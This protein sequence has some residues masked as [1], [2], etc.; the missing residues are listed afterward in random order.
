FAQRA[1]SANTVAEG[2]EGLS[3]ARAPD[4]FAARL[5]PSGLGIDLVV[6]WHGWLLSRLASAR[7]PGSSPRPKPATGI[8]IKTY[9]TTQTVRSWAFRINSSATWW[10][11]IFF[12][13][14]N[15]FL[16]TTT[17]LHLFSRAAS[18]ISPATP[19]PFVLIQNS[20][21]TAL[22]GIPAFLKADFAFFNIGD[23]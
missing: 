13:Q 16:P 9:S 4:G 19:S 3:R 8:P 18:K 22:A 23:A 5:T 10:L 7:W 15:D 1:P 12:S 17:V 2:L 20:V 11:K 14:E 6:F 21:F